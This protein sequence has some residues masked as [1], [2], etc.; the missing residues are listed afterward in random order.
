MSEMED[1]ELK[2][3]YG[4][5]LNGLEAMG[6]DLRRRTCPGIAWQTPQRGNRHWAVLAWPAA[7]AAVAAAVLAAMFLLAPPAGHGD[8]APVAAIAEPHEDDLLV[9]EMLVREP[10]QPATSPSNDEL[11]WLDDAVLND[12][13]TTNLGEG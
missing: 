4:P 9:M 1:R 2:Q 11:W 10:A 13:P 3:R 8:N 6:K 5:I 12:A 7:A